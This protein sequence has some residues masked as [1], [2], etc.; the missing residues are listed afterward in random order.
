[1]SDHIEHPDE[2]YGQVQALG[3]WSDWVPFADA[4]TSAPRT[5]GVYLFRLP[6]SH[7]IVYVGMAGERTGSGRAQGLRGRLSI[8]GRG[9]GA[10]NGFGEAA[11]DRALGDEGWLEDQ[12]SSLRTEGPKRAKVWAQEAIAYLAPEVCWAE[13]DDKVAALAM[14]KQ[15][16]SLL[17]MHGLWNRA[18][19]KLRAGQ[20]AAQ[21]TGV[22]SVDPDDVGLV[23]PTRP[24]G[25]S[26]AEDVVV[27]TFQGFGIDLDVLY[28]EM[29]RY[30]VV[31]DG[32]RVFN[33]S[34][35]DTP[36]VKRLL[37]QLFDVP[38]TDKIHPI[39]HA[40][41]SNCR[42]RL[43]S[44]GWATKGPGRSAKYVLHRTP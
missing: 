2:V 18:S 8:Y 34:A 19:Q 30:S 24:A 10:V 12:V 43:N 41:R 9:R 20:G 38:V 4:V 44:L 33:G 42:D 27:F 17:G 15:V 14:E 3:A 25:G 36:G 1:M 35:K 5:P 7:E 11:L 39:N 23:S 21:D 16:E 28:R 31:I 22:Q 37:N 32:E 29:Y 6:L 26:S 13:C 40:I